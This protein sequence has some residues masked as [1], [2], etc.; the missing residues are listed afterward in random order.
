MIVKLND[1]KKKSLCILMMSL[2]L[3]LCCGERLFSEVDEHGNP[4][5]NTFLSEKTI[6]VRA[7]IDSLSNAELAAQ[8]LMT[9]ID[10]DV[11]LQPDMAGLLQEIPAGAVMLFKYNLTGNIEII[12]KLLAET[13]SY[14]KDAGQDIPPFIAVDHEG[15]LVHRFSGGVTR[16]PAAR[17]YWELAQSGEREAALKTINADALSAAKELASLGINMNLAPVAEIENSENIL[18]LD[19]RSYGPDADFTSSAVSAFVDGMMTAGILPVL[20]HFPGS[21]RTDP[22]SGIAIMEQNRKELDMMIQP[23]KEAFQTGNA[24]AVMLSHSI[25]TAVDADK[26]GSLSKIMM[27]D[28]LRRDLGFSG[29]IIADDFS[30]KAITSR[31]IQAEDAVIEA[32]HAGANLVMVWPKDLRKIH[33]AILSAL[34]TGKLSREILESRAEIILLEKIHLGV[35]NDE[36][37]N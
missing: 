29:I 6:Q 9:G 34:D 36:T 23:F 1:T 2:A 5:T 4:M 12:K 33:S 27:Q 20:K 19:T 13:T 17:S 37:I 22:H 14:I 7:M 10:G 31:G 11:R 18:F 3:F 32:L 8:V 24:R 21:S 35:I 15:G 30:M 28:W 16:L 25:V 26:N